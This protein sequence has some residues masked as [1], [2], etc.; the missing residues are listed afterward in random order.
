MAWQMTAFVWGSESLIPRTQG[1]I[2]EL[3]DSWKLSFDIHIHTMVFVHTHTHIHTRVGVK[4]KNLKKKKPNWRKREQNETPEQPWIL[5]PGE[6]DKPVEW[7]HSKDGAHLEIYI[8]SVTGL[9]TESRDNRK[10]RSTFFYA[11]KR[12]T[13]FLGNEVK[14]KKTKLCNDSFFSKIIFVQQ[15]FT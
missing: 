15:G 14:K 2:K 13:M 3:T 11:P 1:E 10:H 9:H 5:V 12:N 7:L 6:R 8:T 4:I